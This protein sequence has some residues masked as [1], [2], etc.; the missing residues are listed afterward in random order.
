MFTFTDLKFACSLLVI[1]FSSNPLPTKL[2]PP[3]PAQL[4]T[5][6]VVVP[7]ECRLS[8]LS[9]LKLNWSL[10]MLNFIGVLSP[11][12]IPEDKAVVFISL[13]V[14]EF[15]IGDILPPDISK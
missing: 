8:W 1:L 7:V 9:T 10:L 4:V 12:I 14:I 6:T 11:P 15:A 2:L 13:S 5:G 3:S